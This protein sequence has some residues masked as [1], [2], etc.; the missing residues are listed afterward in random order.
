M[1]PTTPYLETITSLRSMTILA[2]LAIYLI[3][4]YGHA[5]RLPMWA[6]YAL[7]LLQITGILAGS[8]PMLGNLA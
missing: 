5:L 8:M 4:C 3:L 7:L 1:R 2:L 6:V